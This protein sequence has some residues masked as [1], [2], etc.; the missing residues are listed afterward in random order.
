MYILEHFLLTQYVTLREK[1]KSLQRG[2]P[3]L[4]VP[5]EGL[6]GGNTTSGTLRSQLISLPLSKGNL[7]A[8]LASTEHLCT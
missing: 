5:Q 3:I 4:Q 2:G 6:R 8:G 1:K 7:I